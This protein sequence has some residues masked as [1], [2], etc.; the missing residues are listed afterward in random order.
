MRKSRVKLPA[1]KRAPRGRRYQ[2]DR[3][4]FP[5][6]AK[7]DLLRFWRL[8]LRTTDPGELKALK[9][10]GGSFPHRVWHM[11]FVVAAH[12]LRAWAG[13]RELESLHEDWANLVLCW[14]QR[15]VDGAQQIA[16][17]D[18]ALEEMLSRPRPA[19]PRSTKRRTAIAPRVLLVKYEICR[20]GESS[21]RL[22]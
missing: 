20:Q 14:R 22:S 5:E 12:R 10:A 1:L 4:I 16:F 2:E 15:P 7:P 17:L 11:L 3:A 13:P 21:G 8:A 18:A 9:R 6:S 19:K